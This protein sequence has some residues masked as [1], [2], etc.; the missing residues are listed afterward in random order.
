MGVAVV[1]IGQALAQLVF[2]CLAIYLARDSYCWCFDRRIL[3]RL[4][5]YSLPLVPGTL[6]VYAAQ[7][8]DRYTLNAFRG[9]DEVGVYGMGARVA[10]L[11][12]LFLAGF[13]GAWMPRVLGSFRQ[14]QAP[15]QFATV[16]RYYL[17]GTMTL[18]VL[19]SVF[20][21]EIITVLAAPPFREGFVVIP[22]LVL[23]TVL[24]SVANYFSYGIQIGERSNLRLLLNVGALAI[25]IALNLLLVPRYGA[26]G[27][28]LANALS[29][30]ALAIAA[31]GIS[32]RLYEVPY[33]WAPVA[34][35]IA[36]AFLV[37]EVTVMMRPNI[38]IQTTL[39][40]LVVVGATL[41]AVGRLLGVRPITS[42]MGAIM[43]LRPH[44]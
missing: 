28:A 34:L 29:F 38:G 26:I 3:A 24:A 14:A 20:G 35:S 32:Q 4:M 33:R 42:A 30:I 19:L 1:F 12:N 22:L 23:A 15:Q 43:T 21:R 44:R 11:V 17:A 6:A 40:K 36:I 13:Q 7:Y 37:S 5:R 2:G 27:A 9:L 25:C 31:I 41:A 16:F 18:L 39:V 10:T 8:V